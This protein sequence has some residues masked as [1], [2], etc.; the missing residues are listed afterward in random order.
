MCWV[1]T[2]GRAA[3]RARPFHVELLLYARYL[4]ANTAIRADDKYAISAVVVRGLVDTLPV[5]PRAAV[6]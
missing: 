2:E 6:K 1:L 5:S 3:A 4:E